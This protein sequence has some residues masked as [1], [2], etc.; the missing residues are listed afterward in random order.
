MFLNKNCC[1]FEGAL[2]SDGHM[3]SEGFM[4]S[5]GHIVPVV[6]NPKYQISLLHF[7]T[8][9]DCLLRLLGANASL[10]YVHFIFIYRGSKISHICKWNAWSDIGRTVTG[11]LWTHIFHTV[12]E[13]WWS[14]PEGQNVILLINIT[15]GP[16]HQSSSTSTHQTL[17]SDAGWLYRDIIES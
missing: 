13:K 5:D 2:S 17:L 14:S 10:A 6:W 3:S 11:L 8:K 4:S 9:S 12:L 16:A 7:L 1:H 15:H